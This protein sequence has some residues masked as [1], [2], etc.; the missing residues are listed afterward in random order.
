MW[1]NSHAIITFNEFVIKGSILNFKLKNLC[2]FN[3]QN[4]NQEHVRCVR[5]NPYSLKL[6]NRRHQVKLDTDEEE[7]HFDD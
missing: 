6:K 1:Q 4:Y 2:W 3:L 7:F 5:L